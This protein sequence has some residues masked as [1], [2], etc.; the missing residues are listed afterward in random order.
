[1]TE[2]RTDA[3]NPAFASLV[4]LAKTKGFVTP[5]DV[6]DVLPD[7]EMV[8]DAYAF[9]VGQGIEIQDEA[10]VAPIETP[11]PSPVV[12]PGPRRRMLDEPGE[13]SDNVS[14]YLRELGAIPLLSAEEEVSLARA[15]ET[16]R[17]AE[18][19]LESFKN[20]GAQIDA[21][22]R[23]RLC[24]EVIAGNEAREHLIQANG[25]LVVHIAKRYINNGVPFLDLIQEGNV[26][27]IRAA[28]KFDYHRGFKFSTYATY[29]IRQSITR[30]IAD[31]ARTIRVPVHMS[32]Q[33]GKVKAVARRLEQELG[34]DPSTD[35][36]AAALEISPRRVEQIL[37]VA[38]RPLS[39][40]MRVGDDAETELGDFIR[41]EDSPEPTE[42]AGRELLREELEDVLDSLSEREAQVLEMRYGLIDGTPHTLE[43]VGEHFGVTRERIR[44]IETKAIRRLRHPT[45]S[46]RLRD[47]L[48]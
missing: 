27:L 32:E 33:I 8:D 6:A 15:Y 4:T 41:D 12:A 24:A 48:R 44:Q 36:V 40:E 17:L 21:A 29:W 22:E 28:E 1:M 42:L 43:E 19:R 25:R 9:L 18:Q 47:Y 13:G 45:R 31:Q 3:P 46:K 35:E 39:L 2:P 20:D 14:L 16:G 34:R 5:D 30:A 7:P 26:G 11:R 37:E 10:A 38:Q 23:A